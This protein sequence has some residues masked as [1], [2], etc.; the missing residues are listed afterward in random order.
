MA[1]QTPRIDTL[2]YGTNEIGRP[3]YRGHGCFVRVDTY[4]NRDGEVFHERHFA[5]DSHDDS[6]AFHAVT[7]LGITPEFPG[8]GTGNGTLCGS[9]YLGHGHTLKLHNKRIQA[10]TL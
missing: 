9:C 7:N 5:A 10:V 8:E 3:E 4:T 6:P 1:P 2:R